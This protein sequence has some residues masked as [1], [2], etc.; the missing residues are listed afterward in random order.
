MMSRMGDSTLA[1]NSYDGVVASWKNITQN[2]RPVHIIMWV[3]RSREK[4]SKFHLTIEQ[5]IKYIR[6]NAIACY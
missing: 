1:E 2:R 5:R 4:P 6:D 3:N